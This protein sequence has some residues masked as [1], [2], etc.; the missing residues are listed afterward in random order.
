MRDASALDA[1][2]QHAG[3]G[4]VIGELCPA[5]D[6]A[7]SI[8]TGLVLADNGVV[9]FC[10]D[11]LRRLNRLSGAHGMGSSLDGRLDSRVGSA[12]AEGVFERPADRRFIWRR[13]GLQQGVGG[14]DLTGD[15]E[16]A[17]HRTMQD[18]G[19]LEGVEGFKRAAFESAAQPLDGEHLLASGSFCRVG[20][21][22]HGLVI[23]KHCAGAAFGFVAADLGAGETEALAQEVCQHLAGEGF[24]G[25]MSTVDD[26]VHKNP[27]ISADHHKYRNH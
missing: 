20:A 25:N 16:A 27:L 7:D 3:E 22:E 17:L 4:Q 12:A 1:G 18:E 11:R 10:G 14:D 21:G 5:G 6:L 24:E 2:V 8:G 9:G 19:L 13:F 15:A 26:K 23:N